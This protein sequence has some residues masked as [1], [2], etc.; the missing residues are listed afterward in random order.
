MYIGLGRY[1]IICLLDDAYALYKAIIAGVVRNL[2]QLDD[3]LCFECAFG[4]LGKELQYHIHQRLAF[5]I[6]GKGRDVL[7][8]DGHAIFCSVR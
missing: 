3:T 1:G 2:A 5:G 4:I 8:N 7:L 6:L